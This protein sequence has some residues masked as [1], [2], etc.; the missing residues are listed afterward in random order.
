MTGPDQLSCTT[1]FIIQNSD[2]LGSCPSAFVAPGP[3]STMRFRGC[4]GIA[5][6]GAGPA[7]EA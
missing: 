4:N 6:E 5:S 1:F 2:A 7:R 3:F